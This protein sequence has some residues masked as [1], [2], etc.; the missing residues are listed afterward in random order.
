MPQSMGHGLWTMVT[1]RSGVEA[2]LKIRGR[3][4]GFMQVG[5]DI[6]E[7]AI[8][9]ALAGASEVM[10]VYRD[11][12]TVD[13]KADRSPLTEA[14]RR[15]HQ[16][17]VA[18]LEKTGLPVLSEE[19][20][21]IPY[22]ERCTWKRFW[23]VD[24]LDGTK[25]FIQR[26]G[27]FTV[28][29]ALIELGKPIWGVV[30]APVLESLYWGGLEAG[31]YKALAV[32]TDMSTQQLKEAGIPIKAVASASPYRVV[33]SRSHRSAETEAF[34]NS[35]NEKYGEVA[36]LSMGS[37]LKICLVAEGSA[38]VYPRF[39]PTMEWDTAAGHAIALASGCSITH[40]ETREELRYNKE[41]LLNPWF[42]VQAL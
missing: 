20:R 23:L 4:E 13:Y 16:A 22:A 14:D 1:L 34:V 5:K 7:L 6:Y 8:A 2:M 18:G 11:T 42:I 30:Y 3:F 9:A 27:E 36:Y 41:D 21:A 40:P 17:I 31:A 32:S 37:S 29:I 26:N 24:P 33:A 25:E 28:N 10:A 39:A 35:L 19:G 15:A 12:I 38:Q